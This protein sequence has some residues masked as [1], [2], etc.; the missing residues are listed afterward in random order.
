M[1]TLHDVHVWVTFIFVDWGF[2]PLPKVIS[3]INSER[4]HRD[5][6]VVG[7]P[8]LNPLPRVQ[9]QACCSTCAGDFNPL[10]V[11]VL[12]SGPAPLGWYHKNKK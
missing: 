1:I 6:L 5:S 4:E 10:L 9:S 7:Y 2:Y 8:A 12:P 3:K 11:Q